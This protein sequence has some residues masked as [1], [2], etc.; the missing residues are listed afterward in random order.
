MT[1]LAFLITTALSGAA[2]EQESLLVLDNQHVRLEVRRLQ[3]DWRETYAARA[4]GEWHT[5]LVSGHTLRPEPSILHDGVSWERGF[6]RAAPEHLP[7]GDRCILLVA[8]HSGIRLSKRITLRGQETHFRVEVACSLSAPTAISHV[9]SSYSFVPAG[10]LDPARSFP[11][12]VFTPQL[13]PEENDVI[14][15]HTF[16]APA[17]ML[18]RTNLFAALVPDIAAIDVRDRRITSGADVRVDSVSVPMLSYGLLPWT[19]R[20]HVYYMHTDSTAA[21]LRDTTV[22]YAY[23]LFLRGD[24]PRRTGYRDVVRYLWEEIGRK[25]L[26]AAAGPQME[27]FSSYIHKAWYEYLP[28]VALD[29]VYNG[30]PVTL[31]RQ[32]R[33]A[34]SNKLP[35]AADNDAWFNVWF[36][37]L[38][39]AYGMFLHGRDNGD[40]R[41]IDQAERVLNLALAA[42]NARG[43]APSIFYVDSLGGHWVADHGW[44]GIRNGEYLAM[45]HNSWT[46]YWLL[47][48][49]DLIPS[50]KEEIT[51]YVRRFA[52]FLCAHQLR[53]GVIP[54]W[55]HPETLEPAPEF[56][57]ENAET[58]GAA[59]FLAEFARRSHDTRYRD[60]A[61]KGM[62][63]ILREIVPRQKWFDFETFFSCSRKPLG[64]FDRFTHQHP[65][66]TLSMHQA[67]EACLVLEETTGTKVFVER[68]Q[69]ILDYLCLYQQVWSPQWLSCPLFGGFGVQNTDGEW[70]DSRQAYFAI[71]LMRY[72]QRTGRREYFERAVA[73]VRAQFSLFESPSSPRTAENYAHS[74]LDKLAGVT[75]L[76]WGTGSAVTSIHLLARQF[77]DAYVDVEGGWGVG[78][79]GSTVENVHV[80]QSMVTLQIRDDVH[81]PRAIRLVCGNVSRDRYALRVNGKNLGTWSAQQ[82]RSGTTVTIP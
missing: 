45:F 61:V 1:L 68:G 3:G 11:D 44:G 7:N 35:P 18:Q 24:A 65:Q 46:C 15:D 16:R 72:Y 48:W 51:A 62:E 34:W 82:L 2:I 60:A 12:F 9:L 77:G 53:S 26:V 76:H 49:C 6:S 80:D 78:I 64:F 23:R 10:A 73:A 31:L 69:E 29:T 47:Q 14:G 75:G 58:A 20:S 67:A 52:D 33:L 43:I 19:K 74:T 38:R 71:T 22:R 37:T 55:Y 79:D 39:T 21:P 36:N 41:L 30:I 28:Q 13:R 42:P 50:R 56:R 32:A 54:S 17:L 57:D 25:S 63:Y 70:S 8:E 5:L 4:G 27:P 81:A 40:Q 66:N 59:L